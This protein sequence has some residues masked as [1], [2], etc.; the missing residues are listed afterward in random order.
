[1]A[2]LAESVISGAQQQAQDSGKTV[3]DAM[4]A[5]HI[6]STAEHARQE[7]DM[8]KE[9]QQ[10]AKS[11]FILDGISKANALTGPMQTEYI[12]NFSKSWQ[13]MD[14][15]ADTSGIQTLIKSPEDLRNYLGAMKTL[16]DT[17]GVGSPQQ[18][19]YLW[20]SGS[21]EGVQKVLSDYEQHKAMVSAAQQ[22]SEGQNIRGQT[23]QDNAVQTA[24]DKFDKDPNINKLLPMGQSLGRDLKTLTHNSKD[25]PVTY[26]TLHESLMNVANVLGG[27]SLSDS[28]VNSITPHVSDEM[29][30]KVEQYFTDNP[31][32][33]ADPKYV[34]Y[35]QNLVSRLHGA[36]KADVGDR[37]DQI[38]AGRNPAL[39]H[40][41]GIG[42]MVKTK[43]EYYKNGDWLG[44]QEAAA[45]APA[46]GKFAPDVAAY[47]A[48]YGITPEAA[49]K[50]KDNYSA[51]Q[52]GGM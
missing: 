31:N 3:G 5:Y 21:L 1:M 50:L 6:A 43:H 20:Q 13:S 37:A 28:R 38:A 44:N 35:V 16:G 19:Q 12:K 51:K 52:A 41:P 40:T 46:A 42:E 11:Q 30:A 29:R 14:P 10:V 24:G 23:M 47:A 45:S 8:E 17:G 15:T 48:K 22:K 33:A 25:H 39:F 26:Q 36:V 49:Q 32:K 9:K 27:G 7:L 2:T 18:A 34:D 4:Q